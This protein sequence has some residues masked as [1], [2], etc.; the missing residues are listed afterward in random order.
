MPTKKI[1]ITVPTSSKDITIRTFQEAMRIKDKHD[2]VGI[3]AILCH[4]SKEEIMALSLESS[5]KV[6]QLVADALNDMNHPKMDFW[7]HDG[8]EYWLHPNM[9]EMT[10]GEITNLETYMNDI[11]QYHKAMSILYRRRTKVAPEN[12]NKRLGDV[13]EVQKYR[14]TTL[15]APIFWEM[16]M[17]YV[18]GIRGFF[19][20]IGKRLEQTLALSSIQAGTEKT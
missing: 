1:Q 16:P 18:W 19:L 15:T 17:S 13:Y 5:F 4:C 7:K 3:S 14:G 20:N 8:V 12:I 6:N 2:A 9:T 10:L 11:Q